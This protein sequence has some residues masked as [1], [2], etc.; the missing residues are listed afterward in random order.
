DEAALRPVRC[1]V[2]SSPLQLRTQRGGTFRSH[3]NRH[4]N[5][6]LHVFDN[7]WLA[8]ISRGNHVAAWHFHGPCS[9]ARDADEVHDPRS[10]SCACIPGSSLG[11]VA[12][13]P[14]SAA[15]G[16]SVRR[17]DNPREKIG[18][19]GAPSVIPRS[20]GLRRDLGYLRFS[21]HELD[22]SCSKLPY[23]LGEPPFRLAFPQVSLRLGEN[24]AGLARSVSLWFDSHDGS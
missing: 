1:G 6:L 18:S 4:R 9:R 8:S 7:L 14:S 10:L 5:V 17:A 13:T 12:A 11:A 22:F 2:C 20:A 23:C 21:L 15:E 3:Y 16:Y 19:G 24:G